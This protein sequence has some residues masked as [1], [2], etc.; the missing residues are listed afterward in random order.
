MN[1]GPSPLEF[2]LAAQQVFKMFLFGRIFVTNSFTTKFLDG[3]FKNTLIA[4]P[5]LEGEQTY[6]DLHF[7]RKNVRFKRTVK[8]SLI[9]DGLH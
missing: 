9:N 4:K 2:I 7:E 5:H 1:A 3:S 6:L 8:P